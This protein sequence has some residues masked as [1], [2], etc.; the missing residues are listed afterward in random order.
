MTEP[1][2]IGKLLPPEAK[3]DAIHIAIAPVIANEVLY[4]GQHVG[5][6]VQGNT[7]L[8]GDSE[9]PIGIIDPFYPSAISKGHRVWLFLYPNT[10]QSLRHQ[11]THPAFGTETIR[12]SAQEEAKKWMK[13][14]ADKLDVSYGELMRAAEDYLKHDDYFVHPKDSGRFEGESVDP[15]FWPAYEEIKQTAARKHSN[16]FTCIC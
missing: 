3:R 12:S 16:F 4:P 8:V 1:V 2:E 15:H 7:E 13:E 9:N 11:W 10:I 5:F 14:Y 6:V